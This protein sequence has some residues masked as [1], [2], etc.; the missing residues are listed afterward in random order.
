METVLKKEEEASTIDIIEEGVVEIVLK[1][2]DGAFII[3][4]IGEEEGVEIAQKKE[5]VVDCTADIIEEDSEI[6]QTN[7]GVGSVTFLAPDG[8]DDGETTQGSDEDDWAVTG[9]GGGPT[10][11]L[12]SGFSGEVGGLPQEARTGISMT[13]MKGACSEEEEETTGLSSAE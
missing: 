5:D 6:A 3:D 11:T 2:G 7:E 10:K 13:L 4:I 8:G 12:E 1:K 9:E